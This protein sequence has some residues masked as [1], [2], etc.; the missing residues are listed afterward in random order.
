MADASSVVSILIQATDNASST[1]KPITAS[2]TELG[3]SAQVA[4]SR[5]SGDLTAS[6]TTLAQAG[7][8]AVAPIAQGLDQINVS[9][10][11][12][13]TLMVA[14][15]TSI[16]TG[17]GVANK[18]ISDLD[19]ALRAT[20]GAGIKDLFNQTVDQ[21]V[22]QVSNA[23]QYSATEILR[24]FSGAKIKPIDLGEAVIEAQTASK[25]IQQ[26]FASI[27]IAS[28]GSKAQGISEQIG[29]TFDGLKTRISNTFNEA[30]QGV[31][32]QIT[33]VLLSPQLAPLVIKA[34]GAVEQIGSAFDG[35][36]ARISGA[37]S[38]FNLDSA[39]DKV[40]PAV[41]RVG[42]AFQAIVPQIVSVFQQV[43][44]KISSVLLSPQLAPLVI[45]AAGVADQIVGLFSQVRE[46][47]SIALSSPQL[48]PL[49]QKAKA[50]SERVASI[51]Q[52]VRGQVSDAFGNIDFNGLTG[53]AQEALSKSLSGIKS[54]AAALPASTGQDSSYEKSVEAAA[55]AAAQVVSTFQGAAQKIPLAFEENISFEA[56]VRA[57]TSAANRIAE[58]FQFAAGRALNSFDRVFSQIPAIE[59][60]LAGIAG[61]GQQVSGAALGFLGGSDTLKIFNGLKNGVS[62]AVEGISQGAQQVFYFT[63]ALDILK[64][65]VVGGPYDL[66]IGQNVRLQEQL[67]AT[68]S[69]LAATNKVVLGGQQV[70]DPTSAIQALTGPVES[71]ISKVRQ[72]SLELVN[73]TSSQLIESFQIIAGQ[74]ANIGAN[75]DQAAKLTLSFGATLGTLGVP[76]F[77]ARQE[78]TSILQGTIDQN[79]VVAKSLGITNQQVEIW[80][81]QGTL[82]DNLLKKMEAFKAGNKLAAESFGGISSNIREIIENIGLASGKVLLDPIVG[83]LKGLYQV[84]EQNQSKISDFVSGIAKGVADSLVS[85]VQGIGALFSAGQGTLVKTISLLFQA[86]TTVLTQLGEAMKTAAVLATP[87]FNIIEQLVGLRALIG[88]IAGVAIQLGVLSTVAKVTVGTF[89][90]FANSI[91]FLGEALVLVQLRGSG[92]IGLFTGLSSSA[93][94]GLAGLLTL[95]T[96]LQRFPFLFNAVASSIPIFGTQIAGLIPRLSATGV[97]VLSLGQKFPGISDAVL[98]AGTAI[99][100]IGLLGGKGFETL[101]QGLAGLFD[102]KASAGVQ[103]LAKGFSELAS[104]NKFLQPLAPA[105]EK[106][107]FQTDIAA[108]ANQK[109]AEAAELARASVIRMVLNF[110]AITLVVAAAVLA[111]NEFLIK[112]ETNRK[113]LIALGEAIKSFGEKIFQFLTSPLGIALTAVTGLTIAI[114]TGLVTSTIQAAQ[115]FALL[116]ASNVPAW[117]T[118]VYKSVESLSALLRGQGSVQALQEGLQGLTQAQSGSKS[119]LFEGFNAAIANFKKL[120]Q[121]DVRDVVEGIGNS[122]SGLP[123]KAQAA[124]ASLVAGF[125]GAKLAVAGFLAATGP[126]LALVAAIALVTTIVD[127]LSKANDIATSSTRRYTEAVQAAI[128]KFNEL[129]RLRNAGKGQPGTPSN[130]KRTDEQIK[131]E[132]LKNIKDKSGPGLEFADFLVSGNPFLAQGSA[133]GRG[134]Q[135]GTG[136]FSGAAL[137]K[138]EETFKETLD[139]AKSDYELFS[140][141]R[142]TQQKNLEEELTKLQKQKAE[143]SAAGKD[144]DEI[145]KQIDKTKKS[146]EAN[147]ATLQASIDALNKEEP[148]SQKQIQDKSKLLELLTK[149]QVKYEGLG[150]VAVQALDLPRRGSATE[151]FQNEIDAGLETLA[152]GGG[153]PAQV[154]IKLKA[155][156]K[157]VQEL[158]KTGEISEAQAQ[159]YYSQVASSALVSKELQ[160][161]AQ[162]ALTQSFQAELKK[163][164]ED[165]GAAQAEIKGQLAAGVITQEEADRQI[166]AKKIEQYNLQLNAL[167]NQVA[168]EN[169]IRA[170]QLQNTL[171]T[172]DGQIGEART[173]LNNAAPGSDEAKAAQGEIDALT[174]KRREAQAAYESAVGES[175]RLVGNEEKKT[176]SQILEE[177]ENDKDRSIERSRKKSEAG[178]KKTQLTGDIDIE[179]KVAT[180]ELKQ[181]QAEVETAKLAKKNADAEIQ[182]EQAKLTELLKNPK[183]NEEAIRES[184]N[185]ILELKKQG[186]QSEKQLYEAQNRQLEYI[187]KKSVDIAKEA[188]IQREVEIDRLAKGGAIGLREAEEL[189]LANT[190]KRIQAEIAAE[191]A[192]YRELEKSPKRNEDLIRESKLRTLDLTKQLLQNEQQAYAQ[193]DQKIR[194]RAQAIANAQQQEIQ[195]IEKQKLL[196]ESLDKSLEQRLKLLQAAK[197]L[198]SAGTDYITGEIDA[199]SKTENSEFRKRELAQITAAIKLEALQKE[200]EIG[201]VTLEIEIQKNRLALERRD[202]ENQIAIAKQKADNIQK[203]ADV[204]VAEGQFKRGAITKEELDAKK[205]Q[206]SA[207]DLQLGALLQERGLIQKERT[208]Q[209][210]L[211]GSRR[212]KLRLQQGA[213]RTKAESDLYGTLS[214]GEQATYRPQYQQKILGNLFGG[215]YKT[216]DDLLIG[217]G[218]G[219]KNQIYSQLSGQGGIRELERDAGQLNL[220]RLKQ[221]DGQQVLRLLGKDSVVDDRSVR[222]TLGQVRQSNDSLRG[223]EISLSEKS[224]S[225]IKSG[226][227]KVSPTFNLNFN[228]V[229]NNQQAAQQTADAVRQGIDRVLKLVGN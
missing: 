13:G 92:L 82:V 114:Q 40:K 128:D 103:T 164:T 62:G 209:P 175:N 160:I 132:S 45:K 212:E 180:G 71:A 140:K 221:Q 77:Q 61:A 148:Q 79:S 47:I 134:Q 126:V 49:V 53:K 91:P 123:A 215:R 147:K 174:A 11:K 167:R 50:V 223:S 72:G 227:A 206:A 101:S 149:L 228:G 8:G 115:A 229:A 106:I 27:Q 131:T 3:T 202:I 218:A 73:V 70:K 153:D 197:E 42:Q 57:A 64:S 213:E 55:I 219:I 143:D 83:Q 85:V 100:S 210:F 109:L 151:Q 189:K 51:F 137:K 102:G 46:K 108:I 104:S 84:L 183:R 186:L 193:L 2:F 217:E 38:G 178:A 39:I 192:K 34:A 222:D 168:E 1:I 145:D 113:I 31:Q 99:S 150:K 43:G 48:E 9:A 226:T 26:S 161:E 146:A 4:G 135:S 67:L 88:P 20:L 201:K 56:P 155:A 110:T 78:I 17:L 80:K 59:Q 117:I 171:A 177:Q 35:L 81:Q 225:A 6:I 93:G 90:A 165:N 74:S 214:P 28:L 220:P 122:L 130:D 162:Q 125:N 124:G 196:Y 158:Q 21:I 58:S 172:I 19:K 23:S 105:L 89:N 25:Q 195:G 184:E 41:D 36:R 187:Q 205:L 44:E 173:R 136:L 216:T 198:Q 76:L 199:L 142:L 157:G 107:A 5:I 169:R 159:G 163:R 75:L 194:D 60:K 33:R 139:K 112:N 7:K 14:L 191:Q 30:F 87:L 121:T 224:I 188:E 68:Q 111:I 141:D 211:E 152:K 22:A 138:Q 94:V 54:G 63:Q 208:L 15:G 116:V 127:G 133:A 98:K 29:S 176:Q 144:T 95:G 97:A 37:L 120:A 119:S 179:K 170:G 65:V 203:A 16:A 204:K 182:I 32:S 18:A 66:L 24:A 12:T 190:T 207:G 129:E 181:P 118:T 86:L 10:I 52:A 154:E 185:K 156:I 69:T 96:N 200:Q 166:T